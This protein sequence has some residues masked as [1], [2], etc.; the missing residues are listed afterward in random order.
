MFYLIIASL[1]WGVSFGLMKKFMI[2]LD[3]AF[4]AWG[5]LALAVPVFLPLL[6]FKDLSRNLILRLGVIGAVQYGLLYSIYTYAYQYLY[7]YQVALF[8]AIVPLYIA[9]IDGVNKRTFNL[10]SLL[11]AFLAIVGAGLIEWRAGGVGGFSREVIIG[12]LLIQFCN[13]CFALGQME[14]RK[15]RKAYP[16]LVDRNIYAILYISAVLVCGIWTTYAGGWSSFYIIS[17]E[18]VFVLIF[19]GVFATGISFFL[20]NVGA[21]KVCAST[22]AVMNNIKVPLA[23]AVSIMIFHEQANIMKLCIGGGIML[24]AIWISEK[25]NRKA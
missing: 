24:L 13:F 2:G 12:F 9:F 15:L 14:Y 16:S 11:L 22:L 3:P 6:R 18:Q 21:T 7:G 19:L 17:K 1:I 20:W 25:F 10:L 23:V 4:V 8:T 5:R